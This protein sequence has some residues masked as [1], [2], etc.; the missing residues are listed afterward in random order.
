[1]AL[2]C[3]YE[4]WNIVTIPVSRWMAR[5]NEVPCMGNLTLIELS[6]H[7]AYYI[8]SGYITGHVIQHSLNR[9]TDEPIHTYIQIQAHTETET[10]R[11]RERLFSLILFTVIVCSCRVVEYDRS[12]YIYWAACCHAN[13]NR[14]SAK[15]ANNF[16]PCV[17]GYCIVPATTTWS[18]RYSVHGFAVKTTSLL[19][20]SDI[21]R[22]CKQLRYWTPLDC[23]QSLNQH[24]TLCWS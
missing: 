16:S 20:R 22:Q 21:H 1:M 11:E 10:E 17:F 23:T 15:Y 19:S 3:L 4:I 6:V 24:A 12:R 5:R 14:L 7:Q 18:L 2:L 9:I 13:Q 8:E